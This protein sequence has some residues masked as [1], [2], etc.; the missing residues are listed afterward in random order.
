MSFV[1]PLLF[2]IVGF[3]LLGATGDYLVRGATALARRAGVAPLLVGLTVVAFGT[4]APELLVSVQAVLTDAPRLA[5][6]NVVGSNIANV[7][8]VLGIP[9]LIAPIAAGPKGMRRNAW[10]GVAAM[11]MLLLFATVLH[12]DVPADVPPPEG[13]RQDYGALDWR[14]GLALL[15]GL[16]AYLSY[17]GWRARSGAKDPQIQELTEV[18]DMEGLPKSWAAIWFCVFIGVV[19][20]PLGSASVVHGGVRL[21]ELLSVPNDFIGLT[22]IAF[23]TSL[24]ELAATIA[25]ALRRN[26]A[27]AM[28]NILGSNIFN[29]LAVMGVASLV[30]AV[31]IPM[32]FIHYDFWA[33]ALASLVLVAFTMLVRREIGRILGILF[34][35]IYAG[36]I[37][38]LARVEG[39]F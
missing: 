26:T 22:V 33:F 37:F 6:G 39:L 31:P 24:P 15:A 36:Y 1:F 4:S 14:H 28:G 17:L 38:G 11:A 25:A 35:V 21:A 2:L 9:A 18:D 10:I 32:T 30:G 29:I 34:L 23:G 20:L 7:F 5:I 19:G 3:V 16:V 12:V 8:L 13:D 27:L